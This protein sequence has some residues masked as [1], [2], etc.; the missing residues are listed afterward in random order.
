MF[1][2]Y[3]FQCGKDGPQKSLFED[4]AGTG[5]LEYGGTFP[6]SGNG[7]GEEKLFP[8]FGVLEGL[9]GEEEGLEGFGVGGGVGGIFFGF[10]W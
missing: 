5:F 8:Y 2:Q 10:G 1:N 9:V 4:G 6:V 7:H 3:R